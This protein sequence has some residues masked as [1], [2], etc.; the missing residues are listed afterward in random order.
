L[1]VA[2]INV[3]GALTISRVSSLSFARLRL[4]KRLFVQKPPFQ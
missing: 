4:L 3:I 2:V 1:D